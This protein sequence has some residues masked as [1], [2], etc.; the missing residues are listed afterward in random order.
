MLLVDG[1]KYACIRCIRGHRSSTCKHTNRPLV[2]V[3]KRGRPVSDCNHRLAVLPDGSCECGV[4]AIILPKGG[5]HEHH[6]RT[7]GRR[8]IVDTSAGGLKIEGASPAPVDMRAL[9]AGGCHEHGARARAEPLAEPAAEPE[10]GGCCGSRKRTAGGAGAAERPAV[11]LRS[12]VVNPG[13]DGAAIVQPVR[14]YTAADV[15]SSPVEAVDDTVAV[16]PASD[17]AY[18][19]ALYS[20]ERYL[21]GVEAAPAPAS[22]G[23]QPIFASE[24]PFTLSAAQMRGLYRYSSRTG[25]VAETPSLHELTHPA[26]APYGTLALPELAAPVPAYADADSLFSVYLAAACAVPGGTC[27]CVGECHCAG[28]VEHHN[29]SDTP[30]TE[31]DPLEW[32]S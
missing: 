21:A 1:E 27:A 30:A 26:A 29:Y 28:C 14:H 13:T 15:T 8:T 3:R 17:S 9:A 22:V 23:P 4:A 5:Q 20:L 7:G 12:I 24:T 31:H 11:K 2:Q 25:V 6:L 16:E 18:D 19:D 32:P 10:A